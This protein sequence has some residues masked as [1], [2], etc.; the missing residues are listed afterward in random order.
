MRDALAAIGA[1]V[2]ETPLTPARV[3]AAIT[4][5]ASLAPDRADF[6]RF[7]RDLLMAQG[8]HKAAVEAGERLLEL[9][10]KDTDALRQTALALERLGRSDH[11]VEAL[12]RAARIDPMDRSTW[13]ARG[14]LL[15]RLDRPKE[16]LEAFD[17]TLSLNPGDRPALSK[18]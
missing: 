12:D 11:A 18:R 3:L 8:S 14:D 10:G 7:R 15:S 4:K 13:N 9:D 6:V 2:N 1:E 17:H 5:A 16:A